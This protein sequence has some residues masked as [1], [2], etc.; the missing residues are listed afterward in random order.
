M[1]RLFALSSILFFLFIAVVHAEPLDLSTWSA[2]T[3][4]FSGG[5]PAG[6]WVLSSGNTVV[7]QTVNADPSA[8]LNNLNQTN[9]TMQ[10]SWKVL[11]VGGDDDFM[12]FVFGYQNTSNFYLFDWKQGQQ[13]YVGKTA[14]EGFS[15]KKISA[16]SAVSLSLEDFWS[17][18]NTDYMSL[19]A[20]SY[21]SDKGWADNASYDFF[22]DFKS[23]EFQVVVK[24]GATEL[25]NVIVNDSSFTSGQFGFYNFSQENVQYA[26]FEQEGGEIVN[27]VPEPATMLLLGIGLIGLAGYGRRKFKQ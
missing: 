4:D 9:Y 11:E 19:L 1:K 25:W 22:L 2:K 27:P 5:Q 23:G 10:G 3:W 20:S 18:T 8:Y 15:I 12:G 13:D 6:N 21:G 14:L 7:T 26:G 16:P 17:S 24:S